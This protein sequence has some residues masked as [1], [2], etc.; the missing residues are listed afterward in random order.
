MLLWLVTM[1]GKGVTTKPN[2]FKIGSTVSIIEVTAA[3]IVP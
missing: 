2:Y 3:S 1:K